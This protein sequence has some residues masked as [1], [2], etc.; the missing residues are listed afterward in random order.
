MSMDSTKLTAILEE[1]KTD[2]QLPSGFASEN[3]TQKIK[4]GEYFLNSLV[5]DSTGKHV[6]IDYSSDF[7][8]RSL[9]KEYVR[10]AYFGVLD[11]FK[12]KYE[13]EI[14]DTQVKRI[15]PTTELS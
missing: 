3:L 11:E 6:E 1:I 4:E 15:Q 5:V 2:L 14:F 8:A 12:Q 9:L 13:G 7:N 10:Y